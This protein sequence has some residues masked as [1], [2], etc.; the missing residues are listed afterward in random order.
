MREEIYSYTHYANMDDKGGL[1]KVEAQ[2]DSKNNF[3]GEI[4]F[5]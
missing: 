5:F 4:G 2:E 3:W 1:L